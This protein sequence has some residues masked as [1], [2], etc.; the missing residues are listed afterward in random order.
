MEIVI[1]LLGLDSIK[2]SRA[3][4]ISLDQSTGGLCWQG[5]IEVD[6]QIVWNEKTAV[7]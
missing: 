7:G 2:E 6:E 5:C 4:N 3:S 1:K